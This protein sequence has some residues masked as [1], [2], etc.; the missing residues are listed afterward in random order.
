MTET[1]LLEKKKEIEKT[2]IKLSE[3]KGEQKALTKQLK[4]NWGCS[5]LTEAKKKIISF[6]NKKK[7]LE[8]QIEKDTEILMETYFTKE[9]E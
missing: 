2:K 3:L 9:E 8:K 6:E 4:D 7:D 1:E 5:T